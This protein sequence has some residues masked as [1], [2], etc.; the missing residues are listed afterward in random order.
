MSAPNHEK[1]SEDS[2][3]LSAPVIP[4]ETPPRDG[5]TRQLRSMNR[6]PEKDRAWSYFVA[7]IIGLAPVFIAPEGLWWVPA[8]VMA[9][10]AAVSL[11]KAQQHGL[12]LEFADSF[13]Y[14]GFTLSIGSL[15]ASLHPFNPN[16]TVS[17]K[18]ELRFFGL[19]MLTT[20]IGVIGR[21]VLQL[22]YRTVEEGIEETNRRIQQSARTYLETINQLTQHSQ[23]L[24]RR[25]QANGQTL[26]TEAEKG[27]TAQKASIESASESIRTAMNGIA[28]GAHELP[29]PIRRVAKRLDKIG[30]ELEVWASS[31]NQHRTIMED[32]Q[33]D[34]LKAMSAARGTANSINQEILSPLKTTVESVQLLVAALEGAANQLNKIA[35]S[36]EGATKALEAL[37][38]KVH[39]TT[40]ALSASGTLLERT[41]VAYRE[42]VEAIP[43]ITDKIGPDGFLAEVGKLRDAVRSLTLGLTTD[44]ESLRTSGLQ[45]LASALATTAK[46]TNDL[47]AVLDDIARAATERLGRLGSAASE[48]S[49]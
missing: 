16:A 47:S 36:D 22:F 41:L 43:D 35:V 44:S 9:G 48:I 19:G 8:V 45:P 29:P 39:E 10:Y 26:L 38:K 49:A 17:A 2:F 12:E 30:E 33:A 20:V 5:S 24:L 11:P 32:A 25:A 27:L 1:V 15:L 13:Y 23:E 31:A 40:L 14:L 37:V 21:T 6:K 7:C 18:D 46:E 42:Q 34:L 4:P 3:T 28:E